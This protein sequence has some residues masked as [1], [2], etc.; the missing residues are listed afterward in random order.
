MNRNM[1]HFLLIIFF[2]LLAASSADAKNY[3]KMK[4]EASEG[5]SAVLESFLASVDNDS[6]ATDY[7]IPSS[8]EDY[9]ELLDAYREASSRDPLE[10]LLVLFPV[11]DRDRLDDFS[12][13]DEGEV[14]AALLSGLAEDEIIGMVIARSPRMKSAAESWQASLKL[15]PQTVFIQHLLDQFSAFAEGMS[16]GV[17]KEY[18]RKMI[19][20]HFPIPGMLTLRGAVVD[21]DIETAYQEYMRA[22]RDVIADT[23]SL[24]AEI[25]AKDELI[26][27]NSK[28]ASLLSVLKD[29]ARAQY[30]AGIRSFADLVRLETEHAKRLD[31]VERLESMRDGLMVQLAAT[32][33]M[34]VDTAFGHIGWN[35]EA[36]VSPREDPLGPQLPENRQELIQLA[37]KLAKMD[38]MIEMARLKA[39]P[40]LT[41]GMTYFQGR[42]VESLLDGMDGMNMGENDG[43]DMGSM[44][45]M[46]RPMIDHRRTDYPLD[47]AWAAELINRRAAMAEM[48]NAKTNMALGMLEMLII[49]YEQL[50]ESEG[51]YTGK[52]IPDAQAALDVVRRGYSADEYNFNDLIGAELTLLMARMDL[53]NIRLDRRKTLIELERLFGRDINNVSLAKELDT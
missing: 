17:G 16:L 48:L 40:D 20:M 44:N 18:Q 36:P 14:D 10:D 28:S 7:V 13:M 43:M 6:S 51:V 21:L 45:F 3:G 11:I 29:V 49:K 25:Q 9:S 34:P 23:R 1:K 12:S 26:E 2:L 39:A 41:F 35:T 37:L 15:Y 47:S 52:V 50:L 33:D 32:L 5:S 4:E 27:I 31:K 42:D 38:V 19:Q 53:T 24:L 8:E 30:T 46:N 22:G